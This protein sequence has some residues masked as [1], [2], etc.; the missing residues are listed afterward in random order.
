MYMNRMGDIHIRVSSGTPG[1]R[2]PLGRHG[3]TS[4]DN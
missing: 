4:E 3:H 1:E 2:R